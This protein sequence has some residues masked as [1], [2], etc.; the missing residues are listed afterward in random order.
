MC[1][2]RLSFASGRCGSLIVHMYTLE[3]VVSFLGCCAGMEVRLYSWVY[4][5]MRLGTWVFN[6][7][8]SFC[9]Q[10]YGSIQWLLPHSSCPHLREHHL[11]SSTEVPLLHS[12]QCSE[13]KTSSCC[14]LTQLWGR[15]H[16][17]THVIGGFPRREWENT[18]QGTRLHVV[19]VS[20]Y[21]N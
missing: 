15:H 5:Y 17:W 12:P 21:P 2:S 8:I 4:K 7:A 9:L 6:S 16:R 14:E 10:C 20:Q 3:R 1:D 11:P 18:K 13:A 19:A